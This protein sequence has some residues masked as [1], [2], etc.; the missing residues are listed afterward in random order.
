MIAAL[1]WLYLHGPTPI[2]EATRSVF[3]DTKADSCFSIWAPEED[4]FGVDVIAQWFGCAF[5]EVNSGHNG[6]DVTG[7]DGCR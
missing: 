2:L 1:D 7:G 5:V 6:V 4:D 3:C